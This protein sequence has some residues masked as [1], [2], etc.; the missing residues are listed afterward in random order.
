MQVP[1]LL[2]KSWTLAAVAAAHPPR[3]T[4]HPAAGAGGNRGGQGRVVTQVRPPPSESA[5]AA[6]AAASMRA[7]NSAK[8]QDMQA[9]RAMPSSLKA[10][11][12][13]ATLGVGGE[14]FEHA[15]A[16]RAAFGAAGCNVV[17]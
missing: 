2:G 7:L 10:Q 4:D 15:I 13:A 9:N 14:L 16:L 6:R 12:R 11:L 8:Q 1:P 5:D 17:A 3:H